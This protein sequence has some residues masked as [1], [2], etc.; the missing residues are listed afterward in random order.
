MQIMMQEYPQ[1]T[2]NISSI[3]LEE[4][5]KLQQRYHE[6]SCEKVDHRVAST[7]LRLV[8]EHGSP[9]AGGTSISISRL[10]LAQMSGTTLFAVSRLIS[11]WSDLGLLLPRREAVLMRDADRFRA[12]CVEEGASAGQVSPVRQMLC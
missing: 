2:V 1:L 5:H 6:V 11:R 3:L 10:E 12:I 4:M 7:L 9:A 8:E